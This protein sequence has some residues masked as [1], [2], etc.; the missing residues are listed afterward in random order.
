MNAPAAG[1]LA[2]RFEAVRAW[3]HAIAAAPHVRIDWRD[4]NHRVQGGQRLPAAIWIDSLDE[5]LAAIGKAPA[6]RLFVSLWQRTTALQPAL[7]SWLSRRPLQ[8]LELADR[9]ERLM[10]VVAW[11]QTHPRPGLYLRQVDAAGVDSKFLEEHRGVLIELL[12]LALPQESIDAA[13]T[14]VGQF[15]RRY[16]FLDKP[17]R[18]RFRLLGAGLPGLG[19]CSLP[20]DITLDADSFAALA[21][22]VR[23]V[24]IT[25][26]EINFLAFPLYDSAMVIFGAG[27]GWES[28]SRASWLRRC[29]L[30]Y[31]GDIDTHGFAILD[32]LRVHFPDAASFLM[33]RHTLLAHEAH[34]G[35][36]PEPLRRDLGRLT[37]EETALFDDLRT[38]RLWPRLRLEQERIGYGWLTAQLNNLPAAFAQSSP[39]TTG[40]SAAQ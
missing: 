6:A 23:H 2:N 5:A 31:W 38:D 14:G 22:P 15:A 11:M 40:G 3:V 20:A 36:E 39:P 34:W 29:C 7:L 19:A 25:E 16:G 27:Y 12:D 26:N 8:A 35:E 18:V 28:L 10:A 9:W 37:P 13:A 32:Q 33:D 4:W 17:V 24:F 21:P 30:H 1:D